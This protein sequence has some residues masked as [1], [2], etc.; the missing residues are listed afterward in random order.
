[1]S[2]KSVVIHFI[3]SGLVPNDLLRHLVSSGVL[4]QREIDEQLDADAKMSRQEWASKLADMLEDRELEAV[5]EV[6]LDKKGD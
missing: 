4:T 6:N 2:Q 1:M 3:R 5:E